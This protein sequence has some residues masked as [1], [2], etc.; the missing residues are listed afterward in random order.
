MKTRAALFCAPLVLAALS[1]CGAPPPP[2][3]SDGQGLIGAIEGTCALVSLQ[4]QAQPWTCAGSDADDA[5]VTCVTST[6]CT[7][8]IA[9]VNGGACN[10]AT[11]CVEKNCAPECPGQ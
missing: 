7:E 3:T 5:C 10:T 9:C 6:C 11:A 1:A 8:T 4:A 2:C